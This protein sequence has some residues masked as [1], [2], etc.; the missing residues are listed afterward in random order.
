[1]HYL[2]LTLKATDDKLPRVLI[3]GRVKI[4]L[5]GLARTRHDLLRRIHIHRLTGRRAADERVG[6]VRAP[7]A[8]ETATNGVNGC[9]DQRVIYQEIFSRK[10]WDLAPK[11]DLREKRTY[12]LEPSCCRRGIVG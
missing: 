7:E 6:A 12:R 10:S 9:N 5:S 3:E 2:Q 1:M 8:A 4:L 11:W